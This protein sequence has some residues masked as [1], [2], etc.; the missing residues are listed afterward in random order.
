MPRTPDPRSDGQLLDALAAGEAEAAGVLYDRHVAWSAAIARRFARDAAEADD[1]VHDAFA[2]L[3]RTRP[4]LHAGVRF[5]TLLYPALRSAAL[6][7]RRRSARLKFGDAT[8]T[9]HG[10]GS[11]ALTSDEPLFDPGF[12]PPG[13]DE[14]L[15]RAV[16]VLPEAMREVLL[17]RVVDEM[18]LEEIAAAL[19]VPL[20]TVKSRLHRAIADVRAQC[21]DEG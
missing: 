12:P 17:M 5:T 6:T 15:A 4:R 2:Y 21:K 11:P 8:G 20:G 9:T 3:I 10:G 18:T 1:A 14:A 16:G 13:M 19:A 7:L